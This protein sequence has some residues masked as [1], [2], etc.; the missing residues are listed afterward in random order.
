MENV[1]FGGLHRRQKGRL[2][3]CTKG[4]TPAHPF[5]QTRLMCSSPDPLIWNPLTRRVCNLLSHPSVQPAC[6]RKI[7]VFYLETW[8]SSP[9]GPPALRLVLSPK[10]FWNDREKLRYF[11]QNIW[12]YRIKNNVMASF[13]T[14]VRQMTEMFQWPKYF[15][16]NEWNVSVKKKQDLPINLLCTFYLK[17]CRLQ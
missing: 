11:V 2:T 6:P 15:S 8:P 14:T 16:K 7:H 1:N 10:R 3:G 5:P 12:K 4:N 9:P 17:A 13:N